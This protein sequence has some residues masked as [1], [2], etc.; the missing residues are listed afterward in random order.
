MRTHSAKHK[1]RALGCFALLLF[2]VFS[3]FFGLSLKKYF[4]ARNAPAEELGL[5]PEPPTYTVTPTNVTVRR[6]YPAALKADDE[7]QLSAAIDGE[8]VALFVD[9]GDAV[10]Q[11][12]VLVELDKRYRR[13]SLQDAEAAALSAE[14]THSNAYLDLE[15]NRALHEEGVIGTDA[16]RAYLVA[17][18]SS[19]AALGRAQATVERAREELVDSTIKSPCVGKVSA[20]Y[21][22]R[23]E[24][25]SKHQALLR[26]VDD[27]ILRTLF[28]VEDRDVVAVRPGTEVTFTVDSLGAQSYTACVS[29]VGAD[30]E[31]QTRLFRVE[32]CYTNMPFRLRAGMIARVLVPI[33]S[34]TN[35][36]F[37]PTYAVRYYPKG[38][39]VSRYHNSS[40]DRVRVQLGA[41]YR[42]FVEV[43][44]GLEA[45]DRV[46]LR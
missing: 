41:E 38:A 23:G 32:A 33:V 24:H 25:V 39:F 43:L 42:D 29:A 27:R 11:G 44:D 1:R 7:I 14:V 19:K 3:I 12:Q 4:D 30:V 31:P 40:N 26:V 36:L 46:L 6:E 15:N 13:I 22:E 5:A 18:Y 20:R 37:V 10:T 16:F 34:Y 45:G 17:Y 28:F 9:V 8:I 35:A 2:V 21:V